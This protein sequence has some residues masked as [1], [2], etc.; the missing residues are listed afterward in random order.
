MPSTRAPVAAKVLDFGS[1]RTAVGWRRRGVA[2]ALV[3]TV[4]LGVLRVVPA[5]RGRI[6]PLP[7]RLA[8]DVFWRLVSDLSEPGGSFIADNYVSNESTFQRVIPELKARTRPGGVYLGVGPDQNFTYIAAIQPKI[9]FIVD[10]RRQNMLL[11]LMYKAQIELSSDRVEFLSRL[12]SRPVP[13]EIDPRS[14]LRALLE[15]YAAAVPD[16]RLFEQNASAVIDHLVNRHRFVLSRSDLD[17]IKQI[18]RAFFEAGPDLR[19]A[20]PHRWFPTFAELALETDGHGEPHSYLSSEETFRRVK[21]LE[22][23]NLVV[24]IVGDFAGG[25]AIRAVGRYLRAH[26]ARVSVFYTSN[27]EFYLFENAGWRDFFANVA[28]LPLD[29]D[30]VFIRAHFARPSGSGS[31]SATSL[32]PIDPALAA[33]EAGRIR[34]YNDVIRRPDRSRSGH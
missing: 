11:H 5:V 12:F 20:Y 32:D 13:P 7:A 31:R 8:D 27:V 16:E 19:Y 18:C 15:A 24:P 25:K 3:V 30:S 1:P 17:G 9:A 34:S 22:T 21:G 26:G 23:N 2:A 4:A 6:E 14:T 33:Y 29:R 10:I 28:S